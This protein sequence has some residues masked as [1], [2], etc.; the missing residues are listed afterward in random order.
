MYAARPLACRAYSSFD[1]ARC[2]AALR[3]GDREAQLTLPL[4]TMP[5]TV[6]ATIRNA[7]RTACVA[8]GLEDAAVELSGA[9]AAVLS[10]PS[11]IGRWLARER[12]FTVPSAA[13]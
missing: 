11:R 4:W 7:I 9:V 12:V 8:E 3:R 13:E 6:A 1:S 5:R 10:D 2:D